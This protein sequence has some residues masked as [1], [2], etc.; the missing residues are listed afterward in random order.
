MKLTDNFELSEF[1]LSQT[2]ARLG[3]DNTPTQ[4]IIDELKLTAM[5]LEKCRTLLRGLPIFISSGYRS[6]GLNRAI[7]GATNSAHIWGG[8][9][10]F[11]CPGFGS[12]LVVAV[13]IANHPDLA[14]DQVIYEFGSWVHIGRAQEGSPRGQILT[15]DSQGTRF[16]L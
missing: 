12:P 11:T 2:A 4:K 8:A 6:P 15:I 14:Y 7:N 3:I 10:D 9:A 1:L 13:F 5:L 16:G